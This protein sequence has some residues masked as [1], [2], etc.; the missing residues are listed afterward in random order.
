[1]PR[2][3]TCPSFRCRNNE[4]IT[5]ANPLG[6]KGAGEAGT[7]GALA[8]VV[9]AIVDA[10]APLGIDHVEMPATPERVWQA[11]RR[12]DNQVPRP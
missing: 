9:N 2:A 8:A 6:A 7:V 11:I 5:A 12:A 10:L 1:M 3:A 4:V